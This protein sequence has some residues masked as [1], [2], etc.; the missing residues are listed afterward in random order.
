[1]MKRLKYL[2]LA[3]LV[4]FAACDEGDSGVAPEPAVGTVTVSVSADGEAVNGATV[5]LTGEST[6][7][8]TTSGGSA[9]FSNVV[10]GTYAV[11]LSGY[12]SDYVFGST[13][14]TVTINTD[15]QT[16]T[17]S[18]TGN[19]VRTA[20]ISGQVTA[21]GT[22]VSGVEITIDG[23][24]GSE[25]KDTD[26][27]GNYAFT[28]LRSGS[29]TV[30]ITGNPDPDVYTFNNTENN[31]ELSVGEAEIVNF[32]GVET[33]PGSIVGTV[34]AS[35]DPVE[36]ATV[37]ISG[38]ESAS[39][40][41]SAAGN[42][43]FT[44]LS[45]GSYTVTLTNPDDEIYVCVDTEETVDLASDETEQVDFGCQL[46]PDPEIAIEEI[47]QDAN[48][49]S[50]TLF[51]TVN[52]RPRGAQI[53][54][55]DLM[56][57]NTATGTIYL[58]GRQ[59]FVEA[60][61]PE[62]VDE[63]DDAIDIEFQWTTDAIREIDG[64]HPTISWTNDLDIPFA[65]IGAD[66]N[67]PYHPVFVNGLW[68]LWARVVSDNTDP[69]SAF[70]DV[71]LDNQDALNL[72]V[73][74]DNTNWND[75][76]TGNPFPNTLIE[77]TMG[78]RWL[79]GDIHITAY[80]IIYS[81]DYDPNDPLLQRASF[82]FNGFQFGGDTQFG[83]TELTAPNGPANTFRFSFCELGGGTAQDGST[84]YASIAQLNTGFIGARMPVL[85]TKTEFGQFGPGFNPTAV[86][87]LNNIKSITLFANELQ[88]GTGV[89]N[90]VLRI[91]NESPVESS[92]DASKLPH[93]ANALAN[94]VTGVANFSRTGIG[95]GNNLG[96]VNWNDVITSTY[97][98]SDDDAPYNYP[99]PYTDPHGNMV[100]GGDDIDGIGIPAGNPNLAY[101]C[102][103]DFDGGNPVSDCNDGNEVLL[104]GP[105]PFTG[106]DLPPETDSPG[107]T[108]QCPAGPVCSEDGTP[109]S[110]TELDYG[111]THQ[112][113][114]L[115]GNVAMIDQIYL[116]G[117]D[118][119]SPIFSD[120][121]GLTALNP[122]DP[123]ASTTGT[124]YNPYDDDHYTLDV[125]AAT[126]GQPLWTLAGKT[127]GQLMGWTTDR[128]N[129]FS[130]I[131]G[132]VIENWET[133]CPTGIFV[134]GTGSNATTTR[135][136]QKLQ[137]VMPMGATA[138]LS[139]DF[140]GDVNAGLIND[141]SGPDGIIGTID[142]LIAWVATQD[143]PQTL[144]GYDD[145]KAHSFDRAGN[146]TTFD[147]VTE[148]ND[149]HDAPNVGNVQ[150]PT[151]VTFVLNDPYVFGG[152]AADQVDLK[153]TDFD[154]D[155][156]SIHSLQGYSDPAVLAGT[157]PLADANANA[158]GENSLQLPLMNVPHTSFGSSSIMLSTALSASANFMGCLVRFDELGQAAAGSQ[159]TGAA[160]GDL[161]P[162]EPV[163]HIPRGPRWRTWD[164][165]SAYGLVNTQFNSFVLTSVPDCTVGGTV[166]PASIGASLQ[167]P[168]GDNDGVDFGWN[169]TLDASLRPV[170]TLKGQT[171][172]FVPNIGPGDIT[173][174]Y[175]DSAGR[176]RRL[177]TSASDW[178]LSVSD[179]GLG[180]FARAY[181][182]TYVGGLPADLNDGSSPALG[183]MSNYFFVVNFGGY[184]LIW[185]E[186]SNP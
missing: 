75:P 126:Y 56:A 20:S 144:D 40:Q 149:D 152:E 175:E 74:A 106:A 61:P 95:L 46:I 43:S 76:T 139:F 150:M 80:P 50:G 62:A 8:V 163:F 78:L 28:G 86:P 157:A 115:F 51:A 134:C 31:V 156:N 91:D 36:G 30:E 113:W 83:G 127:P 11:T 164:H 129:G 147:G 42:Y 146:A 70:R 165:S 125:A 14:A 44:N 181:E 185:D 23:P 108:D 81:E 123:A 102:G 58:V 158:Y 169:F 168:L 33:L 63:E 6:Q 5:T 120:N 145:S 32:G 161:G 136:G 142:D 22:G 105:G 135:W 64:S 186:T 96:W 112:D 143:V 174:F 79:S 167:P 183:P 137:P 138:V 170:L 100:A 103:P 41:T 1:M 21:S 153:M 101:I 176:A 87:A 71:T 154:F 109:F 160:D 90:D 39:K 27:S 128:D 97:D 182:Y 3:S 65:L 104:S 38:Q 68:E 114:D 117:V 2:A 53:V 132:I 116:I 171:A 119:K 184:G 130:G 162:V 25:S 77:T 140:N 82:R 178:S 122:T 48:D 15:G 49:V 26:T 93:P 118:G 66:A 9:T 148:G 131:A 37:S 34:T 55:V 18:F 172:T 141:I 151:V 57:R 19:V 35:G 13:S 29:Y 54:N 4:A 17:V 47:S 179:T 155:F 107:L 159:S 84:C 72:G 166:T 133:H 10:E 85:L 177:T 92:L 45:P 173:L 121:V 94:Q 89:L 99:G 110:D 59:N 24:E 111:I 60:A 88:S 7:S 16:A 52:V 98:P 69:R 124:K 180:A 67:R 73:T 12:S